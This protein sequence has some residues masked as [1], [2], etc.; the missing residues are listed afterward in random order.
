MHFSHL[1]CRIPRQIQVFQYLPQ[2]TSNHASW[3]IL[4]TFFMNAPVQEYIR[5]CANY[6]CLHMLDV[7]KCQVCS[8][9]P[10]F[11]NSMAKS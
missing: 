5:L 11:T 2:K 9:K 10:P 4:I 7:I 3:G 1:Y 8:S 6:I